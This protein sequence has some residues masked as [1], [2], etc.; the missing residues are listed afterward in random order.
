[1]DDSEDQLDFLPQAVSFYERRHGITYHIRRAKKDHFA[2]L[3]FGL[4]I[5]SLTLIIE[6][7]EASFLHYLFSYIGR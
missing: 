4:L 1:M 5:F 2:Y 6:I 7:K 3:F